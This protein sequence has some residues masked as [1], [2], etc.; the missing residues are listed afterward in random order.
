MSFFFIRVAIYIFSL[1]A[2]LQQAVTVEK[3]MSSDDTTSDK[4]VET[5]KLADL[6]D[7]QDDSNQEVYDNNED[8]DQDEGDNENEDSYDVDANEIG[9]DEMLEEESGVAPKK[10]SNDGE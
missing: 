6:I 9:N 3:S 1:T 5:E 2:E 8:E 4:P 10:E 7:N